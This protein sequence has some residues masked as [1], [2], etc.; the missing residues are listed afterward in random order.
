MTEIIEFIAGIIGIWMVGSIGVMGCIMVTTLI[1]Y[2]PNDKEDV[3]NAGADVIKNLNGKT[4]LIA[5]FIL[6]ILIV[7]ATGIPI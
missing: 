1:T 5:A 2:N 6:G 4:F 7:N 3:F